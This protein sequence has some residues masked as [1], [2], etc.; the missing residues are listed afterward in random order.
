MI[1]PRLDL[2]AL[3]AAVGALSD[4]IDVASDAQWFAQQSTKVQNVLF[5]GVIQSFE[6]AY[7]VSVK[8]MK[9]QIEVDAASPTEVD[10]LNY[11]DMLRSAAEKGLITNVEAW[12]HY[13][14]LRNITAHTYD[15]EKA[16]QVYAGVADFLGDINFLLAKLQ[17]R[18][19]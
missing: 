10:G 18:N 17:E 3:H 11:R 8:M 1:I 6:I 14:T 12:F 2:T 13:R 7:E 5:S 9:R 16:K 4:A 19:V 15:H